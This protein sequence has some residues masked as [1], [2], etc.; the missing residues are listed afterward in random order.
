MQVSSFA[1]LPDVEAGH[2]ALAALAAMAPVLAA[3]WHRPRPQAFAAA[4]VFACMCR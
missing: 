4:A 3:V 1:V 2:C